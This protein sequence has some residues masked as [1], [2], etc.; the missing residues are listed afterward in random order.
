M[1]ILERM[2]R[3]GLA[4]FLRA[5]RETL[6]P[7]DVGLAA[8]PRRRATGLRREEVADLTGMSTDYYA[9][10]EQQRGPQ[11]SV[12]MLTALA[13]ALR[14]GLDERDHLFR[15]AGHESPRRGRRSDHVA[16]ALLRLLDR[17]DDTAAMVM[18][19]LGETLAQNATAEVLLGDLTRFTGTARSAYYRW[20]TDP[21]ERLRYP[22]R[23]H[24][25]QS[26]IQAAALRAAVTAGGPDPYAASIV[27]ELLATSPE[28]VS[29]WERHEVVVRRDERKT[30]VHRELG[31]IEVDCQHLFTE[32]E[33]Q[34]LLLLTAE[35]GTSGHEKLR[36]LSVI[37][38]QRFSDAELRPASD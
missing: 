13:R 17:L 27:D 22:R 23:D 20:F 4:A 26:R 12:Q 8:G 38:H 11:P 33:A 24:E 9:R 7:V 16:P 34:T 29:V 19:D 28:F 18:T 21:H 36:M 30:I 32:N 35:P 5:R 10:I 2:D 3:P 14:L 25:H 15:L 6:Q 37:G 31:D 1:A